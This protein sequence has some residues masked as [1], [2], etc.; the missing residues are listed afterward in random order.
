MRQLEPTQDEIQP[1]RRTLLTGFR[2][3]FVA[4]GAHLLAA[5]LVAIT[6]LRRS[7]PN[8]A[9]PHPGTEN[10]PADTPPSGPAAAHPDGPQTAPADAIIIAFDGSENARHAIRVAARELGG[11]RAA[12]LHVW[13]PPST[14]ASRA[15]LGPAAVARR[16]GRL[17]AEKAL[18]I[19]AEGATLARDAGF[20]AEPHSLSTH[21][22]V[23]EAIVDYADQHPTR[24]VV[25]GTSELSG[26]R[27]APAG[28]V[29]HHITQHLRVPIL[30]VPPDEQK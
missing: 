15:A 20:Y 28:T 7:G 24:L 10:T 26:V 2:R 27:P 4:A 6:T 22:S 11:G 3:G 1:P 14:G 17:Q 30:A 5:A 13:E 19:A 9:A 16:R 25:I 18:A 12:V 21:V 8:Q 23:G 29:T